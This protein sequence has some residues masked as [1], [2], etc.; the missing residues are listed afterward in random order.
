MLVTHCYRRPRT[1]PHWP[2]NLF[3]MVHGASH[4]Q[5]R[6]EVKRLVNLLG[7]SCRAHDVLFSSRILKKTGL[8]I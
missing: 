1:L 4:D 2:Y 3:A 6:A 8:R 5:V 7:P